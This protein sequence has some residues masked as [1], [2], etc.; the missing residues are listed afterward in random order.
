MCVC[1]DSVWIGVMTKSREREKNG[2][3]LRERRR[4]A[5]ET[6]S[7][8][9]SWRNTARGTCV[10]VCVCVSNTAHRKEGGR[11]LL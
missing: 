6:Y 9:S 10:C 7:C 11:H 1:V 8:C 4:D 5:S 2:K 3:G